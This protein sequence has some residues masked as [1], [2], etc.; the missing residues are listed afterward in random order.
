MITAKIDEENIVWFYTSEHSEKIKDI[1]KNN[2]VFLCYANPSTNCYLTV[3]G[4]AILNVDKEKA[5]EFWNTSIMAKPSNNFKTILMLQ[6][7]IGIS[8]KNLKSIAVILSSVLADAMI[9]YTKS[10]K[11]HWNV[12]ISLEATPLAPC[13]NS[14]S[15]DL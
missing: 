11:F 2:E 7:K 1:S 12:S 14:C 3:R 8:G 13:R 5:K 10:R 4:K 9:L 6:P 15:Q